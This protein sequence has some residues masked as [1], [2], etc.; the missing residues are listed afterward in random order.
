MNEI[1]FYIISCLF[2]L[3]FFIFDL[4]MIVETLFRILSSIF[5]LY[6]IEKLMIEDGMKQTPELS[7]VGIIFM[8]WTLIPLKNMLKGVK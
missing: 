8:L 1:T 7:F 3:F 4:N 5:F 2:I 6:F